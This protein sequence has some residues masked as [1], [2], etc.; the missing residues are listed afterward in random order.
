MHQTAQRAL[1]AYGGRELWENAKTI[2]AQV[3]VQGLLFTLKRRPPLKRARVTLE[4]ARP[5]AR[6]KPIGKDTQICGVLDG[7]DVRLEDQNGTVVAE[8]RAARRYFPYGKRLFR[9]DDLDMAYFA[10]YAFWNYFT[11]PRLLLREDIEWREPEA[12]VLEAIFPPGLPTHSPRQRFVFDKESGLLTRH[13]YTAEGVSG[14]AT[15]AHLWYHHVQRGNA[16][17]AVDRIVTPQGP[18]GSVLD[19]PVLVGIIVH[20]YVIRND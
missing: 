18:N 16:V 2:H 10:N 8:R 14:L 20:A 7:A 9:W 5:F 1:D 17:Y 15:A 19:K 6:L 11:F 4:V 3:S 13:D 12:G